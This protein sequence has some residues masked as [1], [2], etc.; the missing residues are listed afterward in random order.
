[1]L[2]KQYR[3][4]KDIMKISNEIVY[5]GMMQSGADWVLQRQL[6]LA[7][8]ENQNDAPAPANWL[9]LAC[10]SSRSVLFLN[11]DPAL[12][13]LPAHKTQGLLRKNKYECW[14]ISHI[15]CELL[16]K[17]VP[18][19]NIGVITP[20]VEQ[21]KLLKGVIQRPMLDVNTIDKSQG[22]DKECIL[23]SLVKQACRAEFLKDIR[24]I[25]IA[26]TRAQAKLLIVGSLAAAL[27][28]AAL[29]SYAQLVV[30][31]GWVAPI[32]DIAP[33]KEYF[34]KNRCEEKA[35]I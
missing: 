4:N 8:S 1:M 28:I 10:D 34:K 14:V 29:R 7:L 23:V 27:Q 11:T 2:R 25:N 12:G 21:H 13:K 26:F 5:R 32:P 22:I 9:A 30:R 24:K 20:Y 15:I 6:K 16:S 3:M 31:E 33:E 19:K 35:N 17:Q 18:E